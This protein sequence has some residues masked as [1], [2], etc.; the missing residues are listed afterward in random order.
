MRLSKIKIAGFKS[1][2]DPT[3]IQFTGNLSA[4]VGPNGCGKSNVIDAVRWVM[5]ESNAKYL[6]GGNITD[7]IF[8]GSSGRKPVGQ[9]TVELIF[10]NKEGKLGGEYAAYAEIAIKRQVTRDGQSTYFL[11]GQRCRRKDIT[12]IFLGT[13]LGPRS[14]AIIEQGMI[15]R[16]IEAKPDDLRIFVEEAAGISKYKERRRETENRISHTQDN[17]AR[18]NDLREELAKQLRHLERQAEAAQKYQTFKTQEKQLG[19]ELAAMT[20]HRMDEEIKNYETLIRE[21]L[22]AMEAEQASLQHLKT[23]Y[24]KQRIDHAEV[25]DALNE[26][27]KRYYSIGADIAKIEQIL[28]HHHERRQQF[29]A[30]KLEAEQQLQNTQTQLAHDQENIR[31]L[32]ERLDEA[33]PEFEEIH[34]QAAIRQEM[35]EQAELSL[36][37]WRDRVAELQQASQGP[38]KIADSEKT[39]IAQYERQI[40][41]TQE[42]QTRL[43]AQLAPL[44]CE[45]DIQDISV[46]DEKIEIAQQQQETIIEALQE[47]A[48]QKEHHQQN[49]VQLRQEVK[50][51]SQA[52]NSSQGQ[53]AALQTLQAASLGE[54]EGSRK[55]WLQQQ[56]VNDPQYLAQ[57]VK[58]KTGWEVAVETVL[59]GFL[60]AVGFENPQR[61]MDS[62]FASLDGAGITLVQWQEQQIHNLPD[63]ENRLVSLVENSQHLPSCLYYALY[64]VH[65]SS[66]GEQAKQL[67]AKLANNESIITPDGNWFG[68]G[69]VKV[70]SQQETS[71]TGI[72]Q[73][74]EKIKAISLEVQELQQRMEILQQNIDT[75]EVDLKAFD[76]SKDALNQQKN[77]LQ[78][79]M[80]TWQSDKR[81]KQ[82]RIEQNQKRHGQIEQ[83]LTECKEFIGRSQADINTSRSQLQKALEEMSQFT[84]E[85]EKLAQ[86]KDALQEAV[87]QA[88]LSAKESTERRHELAITVQTLKTQI[89]SLTLNISRFEQQIDSAKH[90]VE[91]IAE[92]LEKNEEPIAGFK[93]DLEEFLEK[94]LVVEDELSHKRDE[95]AEFD[96]RMR[97]IE[98]GQHLH[99]QKINTMREHLDS[100]KMSW[101]ALSVR[102]ENTLEKLKNIEQS[103]EEILANMPENANEEE[104]TQELASLEQKIQRLGAINL[105]AIEEY[106]AALVRKEYLDSQVNDLNEALETLDNAI[107]KIDKETRAK[108]QETF[109]KINATF[110]ERFPRLFGGGQASLV[111]TG[112]DLLDTGITVTARPPG[113]KNVNITQL[114]GGEKALTAVALVFSIFELNP[115]PFCMLDEVDAP[116]DDTNVGRFCNLVKEMSNSVQF[117]YISHN[118]VAIEMAEQLQGVT[119]R[120]PG[121]SRMVTVDIEEAKSMAHA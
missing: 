8:S 95:A 64:Q 53:L 47:K 50:T 15:S 1:F 110:M 74:E 117:I 80:S 62:N 21:T 39:K 78:Q 28:Q 121:V 77:T 33:L 111:M 105:A 75:I 91:H 11:N 107:K 18:L 112:E 23:E 9:A 60:D 17:L 52:L 97:T 82:N 68:Q 46:L 108:F 113:K 102:R 6:R 41:H 2:V 116:L 24:E 109:D 59:E 34:E 99:E 63:V 45:Q 72:L 32:Q 106:Q 100:T 4:V 93:E 66:T 65:I 85:Q 25:T 26:V 86:Q 81:I 56:G 14:Y 90:K 22:V 37:A 58:V 43:Q 69:W 19:C 101:Q 10:D 20:W 89:E 51:V 84:D 57:L 103:I 73:R 35:Q 114:S 87:L 30:D 88:K 54:N 42:R 119:M 96:Q 27:Q 55:T 118:K 49:L 38:V 16:V 12:D 92:L 61:A 120:E 44:G 115:A 71:Q 94:R 70:R 13:G 5:G 104:W 29:T 36:E 31:D 76:A 48:L 7:V 67:L 3:T 98:Q 83:E 40:Q 79:E